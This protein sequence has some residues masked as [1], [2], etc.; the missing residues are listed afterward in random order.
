[1]TK[2][3]LTTS[4]GKT[5]LAEIKNP[6]LIYGATAVVVPFPVQYD[7]FHPITNEKLPIIVSTLPIK[8]AYL[9]IPAHIQKH[10]LIAQNHNI[11]IKQVI[12]PLFQ[13]TGKQKIQIKL[14]IQ[15]RQSVIA[16]VKHWR[17]DSYLCIDSIHRKCKSFVLGGRENN[18]SPDAAAIREVIEETGY[19]NIVIDYIYP[20][21]LLNHFYADYKGVN[22]H[23]TLHIVFCHLKD[24]TNIGISTKESNEHTVKWVDKVNLYK[25][26]SVKNNFFALRIIN[27]GL[28]A[29]EGNGLIINSDKLNGLP[30][31]QAR[32][33]IKNLLK[34]STLSSG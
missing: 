24:D 12:A 22:R 11:P 8:R 14:P 20:I 23:A 30:R 27:K 18:E 34:K 29:Y 25:F 33:I 10:L 21:M 5:L 13:G 32:K 26:L 2:I 1:M 31:K 3:K 19:T 15:K 17:K 16:V 4:T 9:L 7:I 6:E 28:H